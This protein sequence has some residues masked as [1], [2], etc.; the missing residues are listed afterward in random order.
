MSRSAG[1][2]PGRQNP[3]SPRSPSGATPPSGGA[4][5]EIP[6]N[7]IDLDDF[8]AVIDV[9]PAG[10][11]ARSVAGSTNVPL[12]T[13]LDDPI[14]HV[15][16]HGG[17]L[18]FVC[19][20]G[21]R[22]RIAARRFAELGFDA[23]SMSGGL[24]AWAHAGR[25]L[26]DDISLDAEARDRYDRH[27]KLADIGVSGQVRIGRAVVTVVGLGGLGVPAASYLA[28]AGVHT[29]RLVDRDV[30]DL[31]NLHRQPMY[32]TADVDSAKAVVLGHR[33]HEL[34]PLVRIEAHED[35]VTDRSADEL[36][37]GSD[38]IVDATDRFDARYA[39]SDAGQ[40]LGI[41]V[42]FAAAHRWEGQIAVFMPGGPCYRCVFPTQPD[43][44]VALDCSVT[45]ILGSVVATLGAMQATETLR[46]LAGVEVAGDRLTLFDG[47]NQRTDAVTISRNPACPACG[48]G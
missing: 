8:A 12:D 40:R 2:S 20:M 34:N 41:P 7:E 36:L 17:R 45:G 25:P 19:D 39:V 21:L 28:A 9:R 42:V 24:E 6:P 3:S 4:P 13:L 26:E 11:R 10:I 33:L 5:D 22:S 27:I 46:L 30:V 44:S 47:R 18:L 35:Y 31:S 15:P 43:P 29:L 23:C 48:D 32:R 37:G 14:G 16:E 1:E 38:V